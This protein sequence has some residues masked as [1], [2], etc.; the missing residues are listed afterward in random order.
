MFLSLDGHPSSIGDDALA[1]TVRTAPL[2]PKLIV[3][4]IC[5]SVVLGKLLAS[6]GIPVLCWPTAVTDERARQL[7]ALFY[8][9]LATGA[10][11]SDSH[12][13]VCR[14]ITSRWPGL[15]LPRL[16]GTADIRPL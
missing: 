16:H 1:E 15:D 10:T 11:V 8:R 13:D 6:T 14:T 7:A 4:N 12:A 2:P 9:Q 5:N 3:L